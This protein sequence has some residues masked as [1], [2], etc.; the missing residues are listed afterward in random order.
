M[1][2]TVAMKRFWERLLALAGFGILFAF[3]SLLFVASAAGRFY[4]REIPVFCGG[5]Q[6]SQLLPGWLSHG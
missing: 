1:K 6:R 2:R 3:L 5:P 4:G